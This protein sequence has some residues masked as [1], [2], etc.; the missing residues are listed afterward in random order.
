[1]NRLSYRLAVGVAA[2]LAMALA[3]CGT[4]GTSGTPGTS[5]PTA[6]S[7]ATNGLE[8]QTA[9][10][11]AQA[12]HAAFQAATSVHV[13]GTFYTD[14]RTEKFDLRYEGGSA[15]GTF[16][17]NGATIQIITVGDKAY[18]KAGKRGWQAMGNP[19]TRGLPVNTWVS[20][21][22]AQQMLTRFRG[23][24]WPPN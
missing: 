24:R 20:V 5:P 22:S 14:R 9:A 10:Q 1:M 2:S 13:R 16:T 15:R 7:P 12:S 4:A 8:H 11:V 18:L 21:G 6:A 17:V 23:S 19:D 3:G